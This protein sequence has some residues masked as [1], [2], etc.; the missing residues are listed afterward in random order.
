MLRVPAMTALIIINYVLQTTVWQEMAIL[1]VTPDTA[2]IFIVSY[3][4]MRGEIEGALFG[5]GAGFLMDLFGGVYV[6]VYALLGFLVGYISGKPFRDFFKDNFFLP[7]FIVL[8]ATVLYQLALYVINFMFRGQLDFWFYV[9]SIILPTTVYTAV[10]AIPL[11]S[12]LHFF[13]RIIEEFENSRRQMFE[14]KD[15]D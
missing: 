3:G 10:L 7:F 12:L 11:Y 4:M 13:N 15:D 8:F 6:G 9:H 5:L 2:L 1:G 14:E